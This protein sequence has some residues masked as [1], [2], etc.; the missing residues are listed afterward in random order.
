MRV[1]AWRNFTSFTLQGRRKKH[2]PPK[3]NMKWHPGGDEPAWHPGK[4]DKTIHS[5]RERKRKHT[6]PLE[7]QKIIDSTQKVT[8][9]KG[10]GYAGTVPWRVFVLRNNHGSVE[11][12]DLSYSTT[13]SVG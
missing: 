5:N 8:P 6:P 2:I 1:V 12:M 3:L 9:F 11:E 4:G 10:G 13:V 7:S